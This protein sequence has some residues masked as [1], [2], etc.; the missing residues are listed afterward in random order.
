MWVIPL[1]TLTL[2]YDYS[3]RKVAAEGVNLFFMGQTYANA[4]PGLI[5]YPFVFLM[6]ATPLMLLGLVFYVLRLTSFGLPY[7]SSHRNQN[8]PSP[9]AEGSFILVIFI[10]TYTLV[11]SLG[12]HKQDRY[13][14]PI[15]PSLNILAGLGWV[16]LWEISRGLLARG[17]VNYRVGKKPTPYS[18]L[19]TPWLAGVVLV[20]LLIFQLVTTLPHHPYYYSYFNPLLGGGSTAVRTMRIGWGEGMDQVGAYL[21]AKPN[22]DN[23]VV[24]SRFT[25]N[26][27]Q[28][29]GD[30]V[31]LLA[32]GRWTRADYIVLY[33]QQVQRRQ[34]P[35]PGFIDYFQA[36]PPE[37]VITIGGIDYAWIYP[38]P[39]T[40]AANPQISRIPSQAALLGYRWETKGASAHG[41]SRTADTSVANSQVRLFWENQ[42]LTAGRHLAVR[43]ANRT[44]QTEWFICPPDP[45]FEARAHTPGAI[46][47]SRCAPDMS[48]LPPGLYTVEVG[49][50]PPS[51][52]PSTGGMGEETSSSE[53]IGEIEPIPFPEGDLAVTLTASGKV[54]DTPEA[55]RLAAIVEETTP[56]EATRLDRV[57]DGRLRLVAYQLE[58]SAPQPGQPVKLTLYWQPFKELL[59]L[60]HL[61]VQLADSRS[62]PLGRDDDTLPVKQW[63]LSRV[64]TTEHTF[65]LPADLDAPLAALIE[66]GLKNEADVALHPTTQMGDGLESEIARFT[67]NPAQWP[68][69]TDTNPIEAVWQNGLKLTGYTLAPQPAQPGEN[70]TVNLFWQTNRPITET[71][72][73]FVHLLD[74]AGQLKA[75]ND[76]LP[77]AGAYPIPWWQPGE[78]IADPH[79]L[80]LPADLSPGAYQLAIGFYRPDDGLRLLLAGGQ[81]SFILGAIEVK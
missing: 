18:L 49:L 38:I 21:A 13:L 8:I 31:A 12:S 45:A 51:S 65:T 6:R 37:K 1:E 20:I 41:E 73:V 62:L 23:L 80:S 68:A 53:G 17:Q 46:L 42:G 47:E 48:K 4:D 81:D 71:Y 11:M 59:D 36:R 57:Y 14:L 54:L 64:T 50:T 28:F 79:T 75:Q 69:L 77:R 58:P 56:P 39:F 26:I 5:F 60:L 27:T 40:V 2:V 30:L 29:K 16:Y 74:E 67:I 63:L 78:V 55:V 19:P 24:S 52:P 76:A 70:L 43:L 35:G 22:S 9:W 3:T 10:L 33:I 61:T 15:F 7:R 34:E 44:A 72:S 25:H 66:V 32:D